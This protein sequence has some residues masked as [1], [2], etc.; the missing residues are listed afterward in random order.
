MMVGRSVG[1]ALPAA[2]EIVVDSSH[3]AVA[4]DGTQFINSFTPK[5]AGL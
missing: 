2:F 1:L 4:S 5:R 3:A